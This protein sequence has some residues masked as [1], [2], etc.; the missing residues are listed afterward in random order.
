[1]KIKISKFRLPTTVECEQCS[2]LNP[3]ATR[4][5]ARQHVKDSGHTVRVVVEVVTR[6]E[7][8]PEAAD[9]GPQ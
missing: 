9:A 5:R 2:V 7:P 8:E 6:Y 4:E 1:M 3:E